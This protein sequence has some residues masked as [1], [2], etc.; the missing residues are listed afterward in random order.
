MVFEEKTLKSDIIYKG[1][2]LN[3]RRDIVEAV[4][5]N[6]AERE[7]IEHDGGVTV[8]AITDENKMVMV[9]QFRNAPGRVILEAPAG[10]REKGE[11]PIETVARE[12]KEETGYTASEIIFLTKFYSSIGYSEEMIYLYLCRGLT[13]GETD[14]DDNES[15]DIIEYDLNELFDMVVSGEIEDAKTIIAILMSKIYMGSGKSRNA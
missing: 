1:K 14:F 12:L 6:T 15:L 9:R 13:P 7:I 4:N 10:K 8:A 11:E 5:G 3:L 2:I